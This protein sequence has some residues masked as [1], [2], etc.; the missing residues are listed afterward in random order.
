[1]D[2]NDKILE[3][4]LKQ[5]SH[6]TEIPCPS[7]GVHRCGYT[8]TCCM[9]G[10]FCGDD[11]QIFLFSIRLGPYFIPQ[12]NQIDPLLLQKKISLSLSYL[13]PDTLGLLFTKM[14]YLTDFKHFASIFILIFNPIDPLF[15]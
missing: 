7:M 1:M 14:Y 9:L 11:P 5:I 13:V 2:L 12:H 15:H 4:D 10:R 6:E 3:L 8:H